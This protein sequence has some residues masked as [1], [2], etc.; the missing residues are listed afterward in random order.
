MKKQTTVSK[1]A[2]ALGLGTLSF[3]FL[4]VTLTSIAF[5]FHGAVSLIWLILA[6]FGSASITYW[7][8]AKDKV[9]KPYL[10]V[11]LLLAAFVSSV[12]VSSQTLDS[13][14]DGND[15]HKTAIGEMKDGWNPVWEKMIDFQNSSR[16]PLYSQDQKGQFNDYLTNW[17]DHYP[18]A[19]W[20]FAA[21]IYKATSSIESGKAI[22]IL[23]ILML[24]C[25]ALSFLLGYFNLN[26]SLIISSLLAFNP[27]VIPQLFNYYNDGI[28][29]NFL[30][31]L[32]L[33]LTIVVSR[34][35]EYLKHR[36]IIL[37]SIVAVIALTSNFKFTGLAYAGIISACYYIYF[38]VR[39]DW[40][41]VR[42]LTLA[43][44]GALV[45]G[46]LIIGAS[47]YIVN[48]YRNHNP[49]YPLAGEGKI[50]I[51]IAQ[52]PASYGE[53]SGLHKFIANNLY[54]T[55][56]LSYGASEAPHLKIPFT[57][58][59]HELTTLSGTSDARQGGYGV[60]FGGI[61]LLSI[62]I[63]IYLLV[64][65]GRQYKKE[66]PAIILPLITIGVTILAFDNTWWA[67]YLPQLILLPVI[68][69]SV[70]FVLQSKVLPYLLV[71][72]LFFNI[73]LTS[74][75][76]INYEAIFIRDSRATMANLK[77]SD[78]KPATI[79]YGRFYGAIYNIKDACNDIIVTH[80]KITDT[81][82]D[83]IIPLYQNVYQLTDK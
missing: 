23:S 29:G 17:T 7:K 58:S 22:T 21:N 56:N 2:F 6:T 14:W 52:Q 11:V 24:F 39:R 60:W 37:S 31:L 12:A 32:I 71:F 36:I 49:L 25:F 83:K 79:G 72:A 66:L 77:C 64:R 16:N 75:L 68:V 43:G 10:W 82:Q 62:A 81:P 38:L 28:Q 30:I 76:E 26:R 63:G 61:L 74:L 27:V 45:I 35:P 69:V 4:V 33:L 80:E 50:D 18:K 13:T 78:D 67:R 15:Y 9:S 46:L 40:K 44:L 41:I 53:K 1:I 19:T 48:A 59:M 73:I 70:L 54:A 51:M 47:S 20:I 57:V 5:L 65:Y 55:N 34:R 3:L 42:D 8:L